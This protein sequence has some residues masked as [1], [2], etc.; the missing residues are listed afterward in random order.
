MTY[1]KCYILRLNLFVSAEILNTVQTTCTGSLEHGRMH[2]KDGSGDTGISFEI[3]RGSRKCDCIVLEDSRLL[4]PLSTS[5]T[6]M[7]SSKLS[8]S[9]DSS[10]SSEILSRA[11]TSFWQ[12]KR[13]SFVGYLE[14]GPWTGQFQRVCVIGAT[15]HSVLKV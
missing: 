3:R 5:Y 6:A 11:R 8:S 10:S 7:I 14:K 13:H 4:L 15:F 9:L 12:V 2:D 1:K